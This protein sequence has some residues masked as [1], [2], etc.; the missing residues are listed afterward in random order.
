MRVTICEWGRLLICLEATSVN[1]SKQGSCLHGRALVR[2]PS[3]HGDRRDELMPLQPLELGE[4][5]A[6]LE[7]G[8]THLI[9]GMDGRQGSQRRGLGHGRRHWMGGS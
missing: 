2:Q 9:M 8:R 5:E 3:E 4:D 7:E 6:H 1:V